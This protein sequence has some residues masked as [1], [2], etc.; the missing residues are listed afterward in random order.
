MAR[1]SRHRSKPRSDA[2]IPAA[3]PPLHR[4]PRTDLEVH[5]RDLDE[6][7]LPALTHVTDGLFERIEQASSLDAIGLLLTKAHLLL[8]M[9]STH[10][11]IRILV[12]A[13]PEALDLSV[14]ALP[15]TRVQLERSFLALLIE[16]NPDRWYKRYRKNAWKAFAAKF[17][18]DRAALGHFEQFKDH[19]GP[20][21]EGFTALREFAR[22]MYVWEDELQTLRA[23]ILG[24]PLED[25]RWN[26]RY[27]A[28]MPTPGKAVRL[29]E[30]EDRATL[31]RLLYP[32]Y[33][34]LSHFSHGGLV[35]AMQAAILRPDRRVQVSEQF[36]RESFWNSSVLE[37]TLPLS[38]VALLLVATLFARDALATGDDQ[39]EQTRQTLLNTWKPYHA[40]G[41]AL[42][43]AVWDHWAAGVLGE[44]ATDDQTP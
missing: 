4:P 21:G 40:N 6:Q 16:D 26:K 17:F 30:A 20:S 33:H 14:D 35:G 19:F 10:R 9:R 43:V 42:G 29:I 27:I 2:D 7:I 8:A 1:K 24:E 25:P 39:A 23:E 32:Y 15:L 37:M 22:E 11:S 34:S 28:D 13:Q 5:V 18:R 36:D 38:Y 44:D 41:S 12:S 31:A 3:P